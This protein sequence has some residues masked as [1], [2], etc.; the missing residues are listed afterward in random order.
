MKQF[1]P[2]DVMKRSGYIDQWRGISV[3][4]VLAHHLLI[5]RYQG[6]A[7]TPHGWFTGKIAWA[8]ILWRPYSG[9]IGVDVFFCIS[10]YLITTLMLREEA[11]TGTVSLQ[12]FYIRRVCRILPAMLVYVLSIVLLHTFGLVKMEPGDP[13]KAVLFLCN[14]EIARCGYHFGHFWSLAVE[15]QFYV[16][17]PLL[18]L[19]TGRYRVVVA[20]AAFAFALVASVIPSWRIE[21][22]LNNGL[23]FACIC[24]GVL[25]ALSARF[26]AAFHLIKLP[27]WL[28][29]AAL[30]VVI[31]ILWMSF[32]A[33]DAVIVLL[34]PFLIIATVIAREG[35][36]WEPLRWVGLISYSLYL[37]NGVMSWDQE[38][39]LSGWFA[40]ASWLSL[41]IAVLSYRYVELPFMRVG[42]A[43]TRHAY[44]ARQNVTAGRN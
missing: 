12:A 8:A 30:I 29:Y 9:G 27:G 26:R 7:S 38:R 34:L 43:L 31:P 40:Y 28:L 36:V 35:K 1:R 18:L 19:L 14:T 10:G 41:P 25:Y 13:A 20:A 37:W 22:W 23:S 3:L 39:Y 21:G 6:F 4:M 42:H 16:F 11:K 24:S 17:W 5:Y 15:E 32:P 33:L 2:Q 44:T